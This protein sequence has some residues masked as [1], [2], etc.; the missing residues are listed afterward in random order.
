ML[1]KVTAYGHSTV[2][3]YPYLHQVILE[4]PC[5][6]HGLLGEEMRKQQRQ[7]C[8]LQSTKCLESMGTTQASLLRTDISRTVSCLLAERFRLPLKKVTKH[9]QD[10]SIK[11]YSWWRLWHFSSLSKSPIISKRPR[12]FNHL[13]VVLAIY[14]PSGSRVTAPAGLSTFSAVLI[15]AVNFGD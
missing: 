5:F 10:L 2:A 15:G 8:L 4:H 1:R 6:S 9:P 11:Y 13:K 7:C 3:L 14:P 12:A